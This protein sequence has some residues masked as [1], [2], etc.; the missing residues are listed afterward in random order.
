[1]TIKALHL[2]QTYQCTFTCDHCFVFSSPE[3]KGVMRIS[4]LRNIL[5]QG[6]RVGDIEWVYFEG[7]EPFLYYPT[8]LWGLRRAK[9]YGFKTGVVTNAYWA[10]SPEDATEWLAPI[11][12]LGLSDLSISDDPY[13]YGAHD[14]NL[15]KHAYTAAKLLELSVS[16]ITIQDPRTYL[17]EIAW[18]GKPVVEGRVLFKGRAVE[19]LIE[20]LPRKNWTELDRCVH[21]DFANQTRVHIDPFGHVHVC[22][23]ISLGNV[24]DASLKRLFTSFNPVTHPITG[25]LLRGGPVELAKKYHVNHEEGYVDECHFCYDVRRRLRSRFP[26]LL[27]PD[28]MYGS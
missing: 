20:G 5:A 10:T 25:P 28:Q 12:A 4:D 17:Q 7:G 18:K 24:N 22:Q 11:K 6:K 14:E 26:R 23:G 19:K 1:M 21:E 8:L 9:D 3:A 13:H 16:Q 15:A 2:L 27:V